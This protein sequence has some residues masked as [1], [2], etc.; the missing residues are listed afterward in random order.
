VILQVNLAVPRM[1]GPRC[2]SLSPKMNSAWSLAYHQNDHHALEKWTDHCY[3]TEVNLAPVFGAW[4]GFMNRFPKWLK[5]DQKPVT[6]WIQCLEHHFIPTARKRSAEPRPDQGDNLQHR[7]VAHEIAA[8]A[9]TQ[10]FLATSEVVCLGKPTGGWVEFK[11]YW[12]ILVIY[13]RFQGE[14]EF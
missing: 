7:E 2:A 13:L 9:V 3:V 1:V 11:Q 12:R 5:N 10:T 8:N 4:S 6:Q 14:Y